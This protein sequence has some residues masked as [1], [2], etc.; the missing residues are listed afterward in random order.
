[1][2]TPLTRE[3]LREELTARFDNFRETLRYELND[4]F[5]HFENRQDAQH[6]EIINS[7]SEIIATVNDH[8]DERFVEVNERFEGMDKRFDILEKKIDDKT[9]QIGAVKKI[10]IT[11][12][13][14]T[15]NSDLVAT[16]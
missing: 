6:K 7:F 12:A 4:R 14:R 5:D 16:S 10:V 3:D 2:S 1:M 15:G 11:L 8:M 13:H 9:D